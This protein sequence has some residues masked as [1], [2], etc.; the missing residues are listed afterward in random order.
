VRESRQP[1]E[2]HQLYDRLLKAGL[3]RFSGDLAEWLTGER[4]LEV[5]EVD[6]GLHVV[7]SRATDALLHVR[8]E[9]RPDLL[10]HVEFQ[11]EGR[12]NIPRRVARLI[13]LLLDHDLLLAGA[14]KLSSV[15]IYFDRKVYR[16]DPGR[17]ELVGAMATSL[18]AT[19]R[20]VR[21]PF[22]MSSVGPRPSE[23]PAGKERE[24][25][26]LTPVIA[27]GRAGGIVER[28]RRSIP[29]LQPAEARMS[30]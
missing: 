2:P 26:D 20:V 28:A 18:L 15:V 12:E 6:P 21:A 16:E 24:R 25:G 30:F 10:Q 27:L 7:E 13:A 22:K 17:F 4:P 9:N 5:T 11:L 1:C 19:Y 23:R 14:A 8:F 29:A 3:P